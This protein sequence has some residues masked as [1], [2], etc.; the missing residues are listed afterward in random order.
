MS[1]SGSVFEY[2][3]APDDYSGA[4]EDDSSGAGTISGIGAGATQARRRPRTCSQT[5]IHPSC[6]LLNDRNDDCQGR[7]ARELP[8][9]LN[10]IAAID[11]FFNHRRA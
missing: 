2:D 9:L 11:Y 4:I 10:H 6:L 7:V 8:D 5:A 1:I 3:S